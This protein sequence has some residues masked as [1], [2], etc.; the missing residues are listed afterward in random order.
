MFINR[1]NVRGIIICILSICTIYLIYSIVSNPLGEHDI[2][3]ALAV[4]AGFISL[5]TNNGSRKGE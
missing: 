5:G 1:K 4:T 2:I 3:L